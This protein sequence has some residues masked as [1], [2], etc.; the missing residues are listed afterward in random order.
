MK[1]LKFNE[2]KN[3]VCLGWIALLMFGAGMVKAQTGIPEID[4]SKKYPGKTI[5]VQ[6]VAEIEYIPLETTDEVLLD[7]DK[8]IVFISDERIV[9]MNFR[10][11]DVF[12]FGRDGKIFSH[13][14]HKG[15]SSEE[16]KLVQE[17]TYDEKNKEIFITDFGNKILVYSEKGQ[18][19]RSFKFPEN[20]QWKL[21]DFGETFLGYDEFGIMFGNNY[22][23]TPYSFISKKD[24]SIVSTLDLTIPN[25]YSP[26]TISKGKVEGVAMVGSL[27]R[28][29][30]N[31]HDGKNLV[32]A[33]QSADTVFQ[34]SED[35]KLIPLII[36]KPSIHKDPSEARI[37]LTPTIKT[38]KF[39]VFEK[40]IFD[41]EKY[42]KREDPA[43]TKLL[44]NFTDG[45]IFSDVSFVNADCPLLAQD[46]LPVNIA[47]NTGAI[48]IEP[49]QLLEY[50]GQGKVTGDLKQIA[51]KLKEDDNP[52]LMIVKFK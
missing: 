43:R 45:Q 2:L 1:E 41:I 6:E 49:F 35:K 24:G 13:F 29:T 8:Q 10:Q 21:Y 5:T 25:R 40:I 32:L 52:V 34:L 16:Y 26:S 44:Y 39:I 12:I 30:N 17:I 28:L 4:I 31:W 19:L 33:D 23:K 51:A 9:T 36:R 15:G 22:S 18:Y 48:L 47:K 42:S 38:D 27:L 11:G 46:F 37:Y 7:R 20:T 14:N 50:L 3:L